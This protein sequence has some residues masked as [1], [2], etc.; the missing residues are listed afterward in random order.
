MPKNINFIMIT[1][2][3]PLFLLIHAH[4]LKAGQST[5]PPEKVA[6][7]NGTIISRA[8]YEQE[9]LAFRAQLDQRGEMMDDR[10]FEEIK[11]EILTELIHTELLYQNSRLK[12]IEISE[13]QVSRDLTALK[14]QF[15]SE[16]AFQKDLSQMHMSEN[17]LR[18]NM[19]KAIAVEELITK[20]I[21]TD[22]S[23][24]DSE[25][26]RFYDDH[27][28]QFASTEY[29]KASHILI[30][31]PPDT[32]KT[33]KQ[34][35][36]KRMKEIEIKLKKGEDFSELAKRFSECPSGA[37]GGDIGHFS[38]GEM[39]KEFEDAAFLLPPGAVSGIVETQFGYH[40][41]KLTDILQ[42]P[43][44]PFETAQSDI[45]KN[46]EW[47]SNKKKIDTY[48]ENLKKDAKIERFL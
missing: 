30:K 4:V 28:E 7:V 43:P 20:F 21:T 33:E 13:A 1:L 10:R 18:A 44:I 42:D 34:A 12:G 40:L 22:V 11:K 29:R 17:E 27:P 31:A 8:A 46:L 32:G 38:R 14:K 23:V 15:R 36:L 45:R 3:S 35:A 16:E 48:I 47:E 41:I 19:K 25:V 39:V 26:R 37:N 5:A 24:T 2:L 6:V 9:I